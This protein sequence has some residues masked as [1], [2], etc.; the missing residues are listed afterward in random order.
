M[1][2][3]KSVILLSLITSLASCSKSDFSVT[4]PKGWVVVDTVSEAFGRFVK[5]HPSVISTVP[6]FVE[7][8]SISIVKFPSVDL[9][10]GSSLSDIK[11]SAEFFQEKGKGDIDINKYQARWVQ[12]TI[13][14]KG[15]DITAE[16]KIYFIKEYG[17]IYQIVCTSEAMQ[18]KK[19]QVQVNE[20]LESFKIL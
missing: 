6:V 1:R 16:Q 12:Y 15:S 14:T 9:Y 10:I 4:A 19:F 13:R 20:I 5:M 2:L 17:N 7:N 3:F 18:M 11:K 8:I